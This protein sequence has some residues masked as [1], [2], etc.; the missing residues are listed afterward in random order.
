MNIVLDAVNGLMYFFIYM[1][2]M[3]F[4][5][6]IINGVFEVP[7]ELF[8]KLFHFVSFSSVIVMIYA[9]KE[10]IAAAL[11]PLGV[12]AISYPGL[13]ISSKNEKFTSVLSER[14]PGELKSSLVQLYIT[15]AVIIAVCWGLFRHKELAIAS[16]LM[17]GFGDAAAALIGKKYGKHKVLRFKHVDNKKSWEGTAAMWFVAFTFGLLSLYIVGSLPIINCVLA[18]VVAAPIA[19]ITELVTQNGHDTITVPLASAVVI[20]GSYMAMGIA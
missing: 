1:F 14:R 6:F 13:I 7:K 4:L 9:A 5:L 19:A 16:I 17:W 15:I 8:R 3:A 18:I 20:Y 12:I 10:W 11:I 2:S